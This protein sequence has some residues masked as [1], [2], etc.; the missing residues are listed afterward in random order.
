MVALDFGSFRFVAECLQT[1]RAAGLDVFADFRRR[2]VRMSLKGKANEPEQLQK[3]LKT[4]S[5]DTNGFS[6]LG[7]S[8][9]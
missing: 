7:K 6:L 3:K 5:R 9:S 2:R 4:S 1:R 8:Q